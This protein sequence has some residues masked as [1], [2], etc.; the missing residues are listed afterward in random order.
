MFTRE[1]HRLI[2]GV[3]ADLDAAALEHAHCY[4]GGGTAISML[5][6]EYRESIDIDFLVRDEDGYRWL[7]NTVNEQSFGG[8][9]SRQPR[10]ASGTCIRADRYGIRAMVDVGGVPI[11]LEIVSENRVPLEAERVPGI[12]VATLNRESLFAEKLLANADRWA[13]P[14]TKSRDIID[15]AYMVDAWGSI[16]SAALAR[17][18]RAYGTSIDTALTKAIAHIQDPQRLAQCCSAMRMDP[19][20]TRTAIEHL[21]EARAGHLDGH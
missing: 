9:F 15:L 6:G 1:R 18:H 20:R 4:F 3:L 5:L 7:R 13:A 2:A 21:A 19:D 11:K 12:P 16:P 8:V 17:A 10:L 14:E